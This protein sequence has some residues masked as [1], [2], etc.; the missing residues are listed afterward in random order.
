[1]TPST[2]PLLLVASFLGVGAAASGVAAPRWPAVLA[3]LAAALLVLAWR[4]RSRAAG[5]A[6]CAAA[7]AIGAAAGMVEHIAYARTPLVAMA[8]G[9]EGSGPVEVRGV[10]R[11]DA[12]PGDARFVLLLDVREVTAGGRARTVRGRIRIE[13]GGEAGRPAITDGDAVSVWTDLRAPRG[14]GSPGAFDPAAHAFRAGIHALGY[15][16]SAR[17]VTPRGRHGVGWLRDGA[18]RSRR[19]ARERILAVVP[20]GPEQALVR[21]MVL[22]DRAGLDEDTAEAFRI[23]GTYHVLAL[24]GAQVALLAALL[25]GL[26]RRALGGFAASGMIVSLA[27]VFY[28]QLVGGDVPIVRATVM[29]VVL[30]S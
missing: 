22:G 26:A 28:A 24:S 8:R 18:A 29:A 3:A 17:L 7:A 25:T 6:V 16:K 2:R 13:V 9:L 5:A 1:M 11:H 23:A 19:W 4:A 27:L 20:A 14:A 15:T 21:A 12:V 10:A 30:L